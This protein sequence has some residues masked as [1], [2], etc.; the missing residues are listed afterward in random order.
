MRFFVAVVICGFCPL[1]LFAEPVARAVQDYCITPLAE[2]IALGFGLARASAEMERKL[3]NGKVAKLYRTDDSRI[4]VVAHESGQTCE[5]MAL[6]ADIVEFAVATGGWRVRDTAPA[7]SPSTN[8]NPNGQ[9][10]GY[11]AARLGDDGFIQS[12]VTVLPERQFIGVTTSRVAQSAQA[13]EVL[14]LK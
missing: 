13:R 12:F 8:I 11:F 10:G 14:G 3:L 7:S 9:S 2:D 1:S 6:G 5:V 4:M